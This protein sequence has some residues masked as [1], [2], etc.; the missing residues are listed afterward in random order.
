M[1]RRVVEKLCTK[2]FALIF[3]PL[4]RADSRKQRGSP[5][6]KQINI[7]KMAHK[8][9]SSCR[10]RLFKRV[11]L[12]ETLGDS[13]EHP[14]ENKQ[15]LTMSYKDPRDLRD[16]RETL[17]VE[18]HLDGR[19]CAIAKPSSCCSSPRFE[20]LAFVGGHIPPPNTDIGSHRPRIPCMRLESLDW[21]S[22]I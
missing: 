1:T 4:G 14:P 22:S 15:N 16:H 17:L 21:R 20:S 9:W 8:K 13:G 11:N 7:C 18:K 2:K 6:K 12:L 19:N 3:L 5:H 10:R